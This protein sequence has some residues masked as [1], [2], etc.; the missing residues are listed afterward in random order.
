M[1]LPDALDPGRPTHDPMDGA[2]S[3]QPW[4]LAEQARHAAP[5]RT[6]TPP[7][8]REPDTETT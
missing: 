3:R 8:A 1:R 5:R 4:R 6:D 2:L 7:P